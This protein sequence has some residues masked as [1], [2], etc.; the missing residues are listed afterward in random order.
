MWGTA[1]PL[2]VVAEGPGCL[3]RGLRSGEVGGFP[4]LHPSFPLW[5]FSPTFSA[6]LLLYLGDFYVLSENVISLFPFFFFVISNCS[7]FQK[8]VGNTGGGKL[9]LGD[10]MLACLVG[11]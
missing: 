8:Y 10:L 11:E 5:L 1:N 9:C 7:L 4:G 3:H 6:S 2:G